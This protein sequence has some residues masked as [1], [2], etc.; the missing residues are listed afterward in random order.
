MM[1][2]MEWKPQP[3]GL[4]LVHVTRVMKW[5]K[6]IKTSYVRPPTEPRRIDISSEQTK[7]KVVMQN[8]NWYLFVP[9]NHSN[10]I[11]NNNTTEKNIY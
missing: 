4:K 3:N 1:V 11:E 5:P 6:Y 7:K 2:E 9:F 10:L 8:R